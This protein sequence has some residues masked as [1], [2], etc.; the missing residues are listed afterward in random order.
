VSGQITLIRK[1]SIEGFRA[2]WGNP[3][4][5]IARRV[6]EGCTDDIIS[7]WP[8]PIGL[9]N[10]GA[11]YLAVIEAI[12]KVCPDLV[13]AVKDHADEGDLHFVRWV[14]TGSGPEGRFEFDG[15]N[16]IRTMADGRVCENHVCSDG[17]LFTRVAAWLGRHKIPGPNPSP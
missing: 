16:F 10:G 6:L 2:F 9:L 14:G 11:S 13:L 17:E 3:N 7:H 1:W 4:P 5:A 15:I 8:K 12:L